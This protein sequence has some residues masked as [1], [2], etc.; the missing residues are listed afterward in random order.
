MR[1]IYMMDAET[2]VYRMNSTN[3]AFI[4]RDADRNEAEIFMDRIHAE[5]DGN[6]SIGGH[7]FEFNIYAGG[8]I[9]E[10][11]VGETSIVQSKL[12]YTLEKHRR[13]EAQKYCFLMIW[14]VQTAEPAWI[15]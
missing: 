4:L 14:C 3:F 9:L 8:L 12:E 6:I 5:L 13:D 2:A 1:F 11:Y 7:Y 15:S 10:N